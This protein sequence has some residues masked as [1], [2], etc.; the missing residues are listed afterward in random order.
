ML[1]YSSLEGLSPF[2]GLFEKEWESVQTFAKTVEKNIEEL[3]RRKQQAQA[4]LVPVKASLEKVQ[5]T[6]A[7]L[8]ERVQRARG[9]ELEFAQARL[10]ISNKMVQTLSETVQAYTELKDILDAHIKLLQ[11]YKADP[12]F[13]KK[14]FFPEQKA[15][16]S[17]DDFQRINGIVIQY[18]DELKALEERAKNVLA[19]SETLKKNQTLAAQEWEEKKRE[20]KAF[21]ANPALYQTAERKKFTVKQQGELID[22]EEQL[23]AYKK[24]LADAKLRLVDAK[25]MYIEQGIKIT[26]L[27]LELL[28]KEEE[29]VQQELRVEKKDVAAA[30][31]ALKAQIIEAQRLQEDYAKRIESLN[32][33]KN[34]ELQAIAQF[35]QKAG[36]SPAALE[37]IYSWNDTPSTIPGWQAQVEVG[38]LHN[39][40]VYEVDILKEMLSAKAQFEKA[41]VTELEVQNAIVHSWQQITSGAFEGFNSEEL[42]KDLKSYENIKADIQA[43]I[44]ALVDK[45]AA[46]SASLTHNARIGEAVKAR[47]A[48]F[49]DQKDTTFKNAQEEFN[50]LGLLLKDEAVKQV[51]QRG[52]IIAQLIELYTNLSHSLELTVKKI[53]DMMR[54]LSSKSHWKGAPPLWKGLKK[55]FPDMAKFWAYLTAEKQISK[56]LTTNKKTLESGFALLKNPR[57]LGSVLVYLLLLL[58]LFFAFKLYLPALATFF[59]QLIGPEHRFFHALMLFVSAIFAFL[60]KHVPGIMIWTLLLQAVRHHVLDTYAGVLFYLLSIPFWLIYCYRFIY[61]LKAVNVSRGYLFTT[62]RYQRRFFLVLSFLLGATVCILLL[63]EAVLLALPKLDAPRMLLAFNFVIVQISLILIIAREQ[64]LSWIPRNSPLW[65]WVYEHVNQYYHYFLGALIFVIVMS[66]PYIGYGPAF[67][68]AITRIALIVLLL[69][70]LKA[71]HDHLKRSTGEFFFSADEEGVKER[72]RYSK[73]VYGLLVIASF[74]FFCFIGFMIAARIW[75]YPIGLSDISH[76]F[77]KEIYKFESVETGRYISVNL[78][79]LAKVFLYILAGMLLAYVI[80]NFVLRRM[81]DLLL[82]NIGVQSALLALTRYGIFLIALIIGLRSIGAGYS[83]LYIFAVLG[84]LGVAGKEIITDFIGY[85]V[86]LVQRPIKIGDYVKIDDEM[87]GIVRHI[88]FRSVIMRRQNSVTVI[89]PNSSILNK[90]VTNWNYSRTFFAFDDIMLIVDYNADPSNVKAAIH[91]VLEAHPKLLKNPAPIVRLQ[92]FADNGFQFLVRGFL[93]PDKINEQHDIASDVR[94]ELVKMLRQNGW[95]V[96]TPT[97]VLRIVQEAAKNRTEQG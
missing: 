24:E 13:K 57:V 53:D 43:T 30:E 4:F 70:L 46:A 47:F 85:F 20:Q 87:T 59:S 33:L 12:E 91:K 75:G 40:I 44:A 62:A 76:W 21:R 50:R 86:I 89:I 34:N 41:R 9:V 58:L 61:Y 42:A 5:K 55:F 35:K 84:G 49:R 96:G 38:R 72:F 27:T 3:E 65:E 26:K 66:N 71:L 25:G 1:C 7:A 18:T 31:A 54:V 17:I 16:Y 69:P 51:P 83:L 64:L 92:D 22:A 45:R 23:L 82:V 60:G 88:T 56:S 90:T 37:A 19:D 14:G 95:D 15:L 48:A 36:L 2:A 93:S 94:L 97:R 6:N 67:F 79:S 77:G 8:K 10:V 73:T 29:H 63:R 80:N 74:I 78:F 11:E 81:F 32:L 39:H 68:Y 52:E 28:E